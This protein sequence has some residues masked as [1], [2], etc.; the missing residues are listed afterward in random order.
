MNNRAPGRQT[1][2]RL[3]IPPAT[4]SLAA[5]ASVAQLAAD[6]AARE[7]GVVDVHIVQLRMV[8][9]RL[10]QRRIDAQSAPARGPGRWGGGGDNY[11]AVDTGRGGGSGGG[12]RRGQGR[13][14]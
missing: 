8:D 11:P 1:G 7:V 4:A 14:G 10:D 3:F 12:R 9:D 6:R 5:L 13:D 2:A